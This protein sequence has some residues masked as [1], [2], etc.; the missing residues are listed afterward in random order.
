[1]EA[2]HILSDKT[3]KKGT[4]DLLY[5]SS[6]FVVII[7]PNQMGS[8]HTIQP[9]RNAQT[10]LTNLTNLAKFTCKLNATK[11]AIG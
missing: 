2:T 3:W 11:F 9:E 4:D 1:M 5:K 8:S 6:Y 7:W 10:K